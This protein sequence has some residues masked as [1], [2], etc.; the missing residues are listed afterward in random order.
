MIR[1]FQELMVVGP[2]INI[3]TPSDI[4]VGELREARNNLLLTYYL[5]DQNFVWTQISVYNL[6]EKFVLAM[7]IKKWLK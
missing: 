4:T 3:K 1:W 5:K 6:E 7:F 2:Q